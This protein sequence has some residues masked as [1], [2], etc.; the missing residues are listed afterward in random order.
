MKSKCMVG[1][2]NDRVHRLEYNFRSLQS[3][4]R[5]T[6]T[7]SFYSW[8]IDAMLLRSLHDGL[9]LFMRFR[10]IAYHFGRFCRSLCRSCDCYGLKFGR[11]R[12]RCRPELSKK[13]I[14]SCL[15]R[16]HLPEQPIRDVILKLLAR[17]H[18]S[19]LYTY[20]SWIWRRD[21]LLRSESLPVRQNLLV[22]A[23]FSTATKT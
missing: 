22:C 9:Y 8:G 12:I 10:Y 14:C 4:I 5:G 18:S 1:R 2:D 7:D 21:V 17:W 3:I 23:L 15:A 13:F 19:Q 11:G 6:K 16:S 20:S